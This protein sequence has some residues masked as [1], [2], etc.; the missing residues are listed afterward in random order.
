M[1][2]NAELLPEEPK[3]SALYKAIF[4]FLNDSVE[5]GIAVWTQDETRKRRLVHDTGVW[6][7]DLQNVHH[8]MI[9]GLDDMPPFK[10]TTWTHSGVYNVQ[11][12]MK[13]LRR[14]LAL[15][16][17]ERVGVIVKVCTQ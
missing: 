4:R 8:E 12:V 11:E 10:V 5:T 6:V 16:T 2:V 7:E 1:A 9:I 15:P 3:G 14:S 17:M 13:K